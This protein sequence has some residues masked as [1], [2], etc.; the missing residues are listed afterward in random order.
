MTKRVQLGRLALCEEGENWNVYYAM[1]DTMKGAT[2]L[3]SIRKNLIEGHHRRRDQFMA[4]MREVVA[5]RVKEVT[6]RTP[7]W[8]EPSGR[9]APESDRSG[10]A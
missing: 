4:L 1:P 3:G 10:N 8:P 6:A 2:F 7:I 9:P 5:D